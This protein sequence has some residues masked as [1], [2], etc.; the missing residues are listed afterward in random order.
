MI[1][2]TIIIPLAVVAAIGAGVYGTS[3]ASAASSTNS[4]QTLAQRIASAFNLD[5]SKVQTVVNQ[6]RASQQS[7]RDAN[8]QDRLNQAVTNGKLTSAQ[9]SAI[10]TEHNTLA[11][12]LQAA[13]NLTGSARTAAIKQVHQ[14][15]QAWASTNNVSMHWLIGSG[16]LRGGRMQMNGSNPSPS[17]QAN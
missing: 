14:A 7:E 13:Q 15:A 5:P 4:G 3:Q 10:I 8:Y 17:P 1:K 11:T 12:Q 9:E 2:K 16:H 6:Y